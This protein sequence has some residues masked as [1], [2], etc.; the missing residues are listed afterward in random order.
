MINIKAI[1]INL[2]KEIF[3]LHVVDKDGGEILKK[4]LNRKRLIEFMT[5]NLKVSY[6]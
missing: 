2:A 4:K 1:R 6:K 3:H 5:T